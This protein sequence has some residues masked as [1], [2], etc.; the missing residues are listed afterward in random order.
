MLTV[1]NSVNSCFNE[2][3]PEEFIVVANKNQTVREYND[4]NTFIPER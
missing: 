1:F 4:N 2:Q 3:A